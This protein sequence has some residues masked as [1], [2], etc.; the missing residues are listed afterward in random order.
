MALYRYSALDLHGTVVRGWLHADSADELQQR[1][2]Q[3]GLQ[4]IRNWRGL[5]SMSRT[6]A[7]RDLLSLLLMLEQLTRSGVPLLDALTGL[8]DHQTGPMRLVI[9]TLLADITHGQPLSQAMAGQPEVFNPLCISL[10]RAGEQSGRLDDALRQLADTLQWQDETA[11]QIRS[12]LL[13]PLLVGGLVL[14]VTLFLLLYLVP[15]LATV[16][17]SLGQPLSLSTRVLLTLSEGVRQGWPALP[18][19]PILTWMAA[20]HWTD[21]P[22]RALRLDAFK[23]RLSLIG[24]L[25]HKHLLAR[26]AN[27]LSMLYAAGIPLLEGL[28]LCRD[29]SSNRALSAAVAQARLAIE[30][31][32]T[33]TQGF[34]RSS[35]FP[36]L[37]LQ[38]IHIGEESGRLDLALRNVSYFYGREVNEAM[39]RL[40]TLLEPA[41]TVFL[42]LVL[43]W[44]ML[45]ILLPVYD[46]I[47]RIG[48]R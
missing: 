47:S 48:L 32:A 27:T 45:S 39:R 35:L 43:G 36:P 20:R 14:G 19:L 12:L 3:G 37:V 13:Y 33:L 17:H 30:E 11:T 21:D 8:R 10:V 5:P 42:G 4:L 7:R 6:V 34:Q 44:I 9:A 41:L 25:L 16:M 29:L 18:L 31:G 40:Q 26:L 15:Q 24:P 22:Q 2:R 46:L 38:M 1:L 28:A 23:L